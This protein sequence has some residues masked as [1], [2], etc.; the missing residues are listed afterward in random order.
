MRKS[1]K[2]K[3]TIGVNTFDKVKFLHPEDA[4][5]DAE[6]MNKLPTTI[7]KFIAYKCTTCNFFHIGRSVENNITEIDYFNKTIKENKEI[8]EKLPD[9]NIGA[10]LYAQRMR[11]KATQIHTTIIIKEEPVEEQLNIPTVEPKKQDIKEIINNIEINTE[12]KIMNT[13]AV[14]I[15]EKSKETYYSYYIEYFNKN[16][17]YFYLFLY[18]FICFVFLI[19]LK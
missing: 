5:K 4:I 6:R 15:T 7:R 18:V 1:H 8:K 2:C 12:K 19:L 13:K 10:S 16:N 9:I 11:E 14:N 17:N 3:Y